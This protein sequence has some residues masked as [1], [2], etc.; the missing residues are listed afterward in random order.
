MV[1]KALACSRYIVELKGVEKYRKIKELDSSF[2]Y[3]FLQAYAAARMA[4]STL[5]G[6]NGEPNIYE[7]SYVQSDVSWE[8]N[9]GRQGALSCGSLQAWPMP[10]RTRTS[11]SLVVPFCFLCNTCN[12]CSSVLLRLS[13]VVPTLQARF[14]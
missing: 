9:M 4:E 6:L 5:M 14:C 8:C 1:E 2:T 12:C 7:C 3:I 13:Q 11:Q 10:P